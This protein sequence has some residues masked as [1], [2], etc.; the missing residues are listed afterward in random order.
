MA[1]AAH[2]GLAALER[3]FGRWRALQQAVA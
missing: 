2:V 1:A 3:H